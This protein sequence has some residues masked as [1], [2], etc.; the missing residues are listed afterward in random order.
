MAPLLEL[1]PLLLRLAEAFSQTRELLPFLGVCSHGDRCLCCHGKSQNLRGR[2]LDLPI[3]SAAEL[4]RL[5]GS[6][7][8]LQPL[9]GRE[10]SRPVMK[11]RCVT[12]DSACSI[13][14]SVS[15]SSRSAAF[16]CSSCFRC[17]DSR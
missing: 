5:G 1:H 16:S 17:S 10:R 12:G 7:A 3:Q 11:R 15:S 6:S 2:G 14:P 4:C 8:V 13:R 9:I